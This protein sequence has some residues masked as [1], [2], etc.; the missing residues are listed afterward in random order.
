MD[1]TQVTMILIAVCVAFLIT[2]TVILWY[3]LK[4]INFGIATLANDTK[5]FS[6]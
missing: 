2:I 1:T 6:D 3:Y 5:V 4:N